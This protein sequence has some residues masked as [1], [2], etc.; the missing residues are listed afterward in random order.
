MRG[1]HYREDQLVGDM[2]L[3]HYLGSDGLVKLLVMFEQPLEDEQE[4]ID[5]IRRLHV[6]H[7]E[8]A[9]LYWSRARAD[10]FFQGT[11]EYYPYL[12]ETLAR[13]TEKYGDGSW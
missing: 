3:E 8:E 7:Y 10:G 5:V 4:L 9:R 12:Q 11:N 13:V 6:P 2:P 1:C